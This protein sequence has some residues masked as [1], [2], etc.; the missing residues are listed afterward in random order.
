MRAA[1]S[2]T[3]R[4]AVGNTYTASVFLNIAAFVDA[5]GYALE[6]KLAVGIS[7]SSGVLATMFDLI[8]RQQ[9]QFT[10]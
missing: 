7:Y 9:Q 8:E 2:C 6:G 3:L 1:R 5:V 10:L 4:L